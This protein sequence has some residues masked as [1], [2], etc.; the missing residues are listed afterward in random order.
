M[1][2]QTSCF[3]LQISFS[4]PHFFLAKQTIT[5]TCKCIKFDLAEILHTCR[6]S[7][8]ITSTT[9]DANPYKIFK[10]VVVHSVTTEAVQWF[11]TTHLKF[12]FQLAILSLLTTHVIST[13]TVHY[14]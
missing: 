8:E 9:V 4:S 2:E 10:V 11:E 12:N 5:I 7:E 14:I 1:S 6:A 13:C 3:F